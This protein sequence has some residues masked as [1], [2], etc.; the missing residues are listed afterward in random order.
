LPFE[1][2]ADIPF[3]ALGV[4]TVLPLTY[5]EGVAKGRLSLPR[6]AEVLSGAPARAFG[7]PPSKGAIAPGADAGLVVDPSVSWRLDERQ[8]HSEAGYSNWHGWELQ[9]KPVLSLLRGQV[10][11]EG[12]QLR[13]E[14]GYGSHLPR[15]VEQLQTA[16][17]CRA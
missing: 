11:L 16:P 5:S 10:L 14:P 6:L 13:V 4:E 2:L 7:L 17:T 8:L 9:G 15:S 1:R 12:D 3:G